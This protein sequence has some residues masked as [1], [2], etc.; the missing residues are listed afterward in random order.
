MSFQNEIFETFEKLFF[1]ERIIQRVSHIK[2][3]NYKCD[4]LYKKNHKA[5][6]GKKITKPLPA[7][8]SLYPLH[9]PRSRGTETPKGEEDKQ[10]ELLIVL[11]VVLR[12]F[13]SAAVKR[14]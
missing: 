10:L 7:Q 8:W 1:S 6:P 11:P 9:F 4:T 2:L 13:P 14:K 12:C 3:I 5:S